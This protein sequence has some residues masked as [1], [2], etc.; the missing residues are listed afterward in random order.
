MASVALSC[1]T[2]AIT[3]F[4]LVSCNKAKAE[5]P[6]IG[7]LNGLWIVTQTDDQ[8]P[9]YGSTY[10]SIIIK[11]DSSMI[12]DTKGPSQHLSI[13]NWTL[14]SNNLL[15]CN[16]TVVYGLQVNLG[17]Q[18]ILSCQYNKASNTISAGTWITYP[19]GSSTGKFTAKKIY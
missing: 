10:F 15:N 7:T 4:Q 8:H 12:A 3:L 17:H 9:E 14:S 18:Q 5:M 19:G 1:L 16:T 13:G 2:G 11:P 6:C